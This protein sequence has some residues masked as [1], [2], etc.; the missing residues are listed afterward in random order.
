MKRIVAVFLFAICIGCK[1]SQPDMSPS[2]KAYMDEVITLLKTH[3]INRK[4][5]DWDELTAKATARAKNAA[6]VKDTYDAV[7]FAVAELG[8]HHSYFTA[9]IHEE[10][11]EENELPIYADEEVPAEIGYIRLPFC[12]GNEQ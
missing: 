3:S 12:M 9:N 8:D 6:S 7:A 2:A 1:S 5:I 10:E 4:T 11:V